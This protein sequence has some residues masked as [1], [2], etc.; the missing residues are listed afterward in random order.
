MMRRHPRAKHHNPARRL[1]RLARIK[2]G[3]TQTH[4]AELA[5]VHQTEV[6]AVEIGSAGKAVV[7]K[8]RAVMLT[9]LLIRRQPD[10]TDICRAEVQADCNPKLREQI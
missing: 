5:G 9:E 2:L 6:S 10:M 7:A 4:I 8:V 3:L 1:W